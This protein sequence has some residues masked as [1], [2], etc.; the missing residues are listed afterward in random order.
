[1]DNGLQPHF[2]TTCSNTSSVAPRSR[3]SGIEVW[4]ETECSE[5]ADVF[6]IIESLMPVDFYLASSTGHVSSGQIFLGQHLNLGSNC[7]NRVLP[8][9]T[10][11]AEVSGASTNALTLLT[12]RFTDDS[13]V[14]YPFRSRSIR[15]KVCTEPRPLSPSSRE[16]VLAST[17][18]GPVWT[19]AIGNGVKQ[20]RSAF[21]LP[22]IGS[23]GNLRDVLNG[24]RFLEILPLLHFLNEDGIAGEYQGPPLRACFMFD[25]PNLHWPRYGFVDFREIAAHATTENYHVSFATIPLDTWFTHARTAELFRT[26]RDRLSL[27]VHGNNHTKR[28][29]AREYTPDEGVALLGQALTRIERL[30]HNASLEVAR[31]MVPPHGA[32]SEAML[33][34]LSVCGFEAA[35]ISHGSLRAHNK[36]K[37]WTRTLGYLP[38]E[39]IQGCPVLPRW[40]LSGNTTNA[41]LLAA[42]LNQAIILRGHQ[43]DLRHG[44][45]LLDHH[46]RFINSLGNVQWSGLAGISRS[47]YLWRMDGKTLRVKPLG[48]NLKVRLPERATGLVIE[49]SCEPDWKNWKTGAVDGSGVDLG[50]DEHLALNGGLGEAIGI[51]AAASMLPCPKSV[52]LASPTKAFLRRILTEGR[53]RLTASARSMG[54]GFV[55]LTCPRKSR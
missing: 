49:A 44:L 24:E 53:D 29:L 16:R 11:P 25:D 15:C 19:V 40:G 50:V 43:D 34:A 26:S 3:R 18:A 7:K 20:F 13:N 36:G 52:V 42:F 30:E 10:L 38:S 51:E 32:C 4:C 2:D 47:N 8:R 22:G 37:G 14:P 5:A 39:L 23:H 21:P 41:I 48:R 35:C 54:S 9:L 1:M 27:L 45:E 55:R 31:V 17:E 12:V 28:E 6:P 33:A 46:A